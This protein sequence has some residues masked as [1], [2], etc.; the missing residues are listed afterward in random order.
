MTLFTL[1][2]KKFTK[3][4]RAVILCLRIA[5][6]CTSRSVTQFASL[7]KRWLTQVHCWISIYSR[8]YWCQL[9]NSFM[10]FTVCFRVELWFSCSISWGT[11]YISFWWL[12]QN[13]ICIRITLGSP[14]YTQT[15]KL[16]VKLITYKCTSIFKIWLCKLWVRNWENWVTEMY[17]FP[18][19]TEEYIRLNDKI[20]E[21]YKTLWQVKNVRTWQ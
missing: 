16:H 8:L 13:K 14:Q 18:M 15:Y 1:G 17:N 2:L 9:A 6:K 20:T 12:K 19:T 21:Q 4:F 7:I 11:V 3:T 5:K 10:W